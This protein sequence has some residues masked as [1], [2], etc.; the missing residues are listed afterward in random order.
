MEP[1]GTSTLNSGTLMWNL[2]EPEL[3]TVEPLCA[4]LWNLNFKNGTHVRNLAGPGPRLRAAAPKQLEEPQAFP[5]N[6]KVP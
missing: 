4:T 2:V 1:G 6:S 5:L 3:L